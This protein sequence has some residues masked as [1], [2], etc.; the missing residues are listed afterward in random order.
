MYNVAVF[1]PNFR[2]LSLQNIYIFA[3]KN[4]E[5]KTVRSFDILPKFSSRPFVC[6]KE[7]QN[8][9]ILCITLGSIE[10]IC[11]WEETSGIVNTR[12][13]GIGK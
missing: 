5:K 10:N 3:L 6:R 7:E 12:Y 1:P 13:I 8:M 4:L 9:K 11:K 2:R